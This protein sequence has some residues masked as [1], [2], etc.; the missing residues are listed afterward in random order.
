MRTVSEFPHEVEETEHLWIEMSDGTRLA[1]G[2]WK[3]ASADREPVPGVVEMI[4]YR[5][6]DLTAIRDSIHHPYMAGHGY[7]SLRVDLRGSG[8]S[9]GVL[10]DE[11]LEQEL[12][13]A[14]EVLAWLAEQPW[15]SGRTHDGH[16]VGRVQRAAGG[17]P[18]APEP[19]RDSLRQLHRRPLHRRRPLHGRQPADR[20][21]VLGLDHVRLQRLPTGSGDRRPAVARDVAAA[22][23]GQ[24]SVAGDLAAPP[25]AR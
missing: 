22:P 13:D 4:P 15:C 6:R 10:T 12:C 25:A 8:D 16:L 2:M 5:K 17:R 9:E 14:E 3:P 21:P 18:S 20:Q 23:R 7:A 11:Y 19:G 1:A 24:R